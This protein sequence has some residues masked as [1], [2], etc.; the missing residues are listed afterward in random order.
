MTEP[1]PTPTEDDPTLE[2][3]TQSGG[4]YIERWEPPESD[5]P[6]GHITKEPQD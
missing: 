2:E 1:A 3:S 6:Q 5:T 4:D